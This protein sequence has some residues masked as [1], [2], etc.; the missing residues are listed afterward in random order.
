[1]HVQMK[2]SPPKNYSINLIH[3]MTKLWVAFMLLFLVVTANSFAQVLEPVKWKYDSKILNEKEAELIFTATIDDTWHLY[4]QNIQDGGPIKTSFY[5]NSLEDIEFLDKNV[6]IEEEEGFEPG[7]KLYRVV[8][9]EAPEPEEENDPNFNM[10]LKYFSHQAVFTQ[11]IKFDS[12]HP[13]VLN[14]FL[15]FMCCDDEKCLPP[16]EI[17]FE[18]KLGAKS[19]ILEPVKWKYKS[20]ILSENEAEL[21]FTAS[22]DDHWHLYSQ[23]INDGGPIKT[24]FFFNSLEGVEFIDKDVKIEEEEG[25]EPGSKLYRVIFNESPAPDEENDPMFKMLLKYFSHEAVFTQKIKFDS[26]EPVVLD[27][28]LEFMCCDDEKC[29]PPTE[30]EFEFRFNEDKASTAPVSMDAEGKLKDDSGLWWLFFLSFGAGLLAILTPCVFPMIPMTVTFFMHDTDNKKKA[31]FQAL[32]YGFSIIAIYTIVGTVVAVTLGANFA[33]WLST[34]WL[35]NVLFFLIFVFFAASFLGMFEITLPSWMINKT[36]KQADKGGFTGAFFMAFTL[37]LVSF[38][39]TGPIVGAILVKS[40]GGEILE[41]IVGMFGFSLA[42]ALPFSLFAFFPSLLSNLPKSGGWLN[43]VKVVLGFLELALGLKFLSIADQTYHW[44][45][46]DREIYLAFWI[47]IFTLMGFYLLGKLKF[48]HDSDLPYISVPRALLAI[49]TFSFVIYMV[50]GMFGAPLKALSGYMP[51]QQ[52][53]DFDMNQI[54]RD[55]LKVATFSGGE[56]TEKPDECERPKYADFLHL[57]HGLEGYF[58]Y[59]QALACAKAMDKPLFIDFTGHGCVN[60]REM[61][62]NVWSAPEVFRRLRDDYI[63]VALYVDDKTKLAQ[64]EWVESSYDGKMKKTVGK[65]YA[66]LQITRFDV[67]AQPYYVLLDTD[68]E[69]LV[70]PRAYDLDVDEFIDFLDRGLEEFQKRQ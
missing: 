49:I 10:L 39:C 25:F 58:D 33:N 38:S 5:F 21:I 42:F 36:D 53:H 45:I 47:V 17:D 6:K 13:P 3:S 20:K 4:S 63:V 24:S 59:D 44:G 69:V 52:S 29:L 56:I 26:N 50:P 67:N 30:V 12:E 62:A 23:N 35:P 8:F 48:A 68:G 28:F 51:P 34:H 22:I 60:C 40:A 41:P 70:N 61:E 46:L 66:D 57:P 65:V 64:D 1:M 2:N 19:G 55:N 54:V 31:K 9:N 7:S 18:F 37:V 15:E 43:S 11:K 27:G 14:G 16:T 32:V